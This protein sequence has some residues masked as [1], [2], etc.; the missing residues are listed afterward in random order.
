[1]ILGLTLAAAAL[2][3]L[4]P[5]PMKVL[6]DHVLQPSPAHNELER[7]FAHYGLS[8]SRGLFLGIAAIGTVALFALYS[9]LEAALVSLWTFAGRRMVYDVAQDLFAQLQR[10]SLI[11]HARSSVGNLLATITGDSW[12]V[13]K[14]VDALLYAPFHAALTIVLMVVLMAKLDMKLMLLSVAIAPLMV[15]A[16]LLI[17]KPLHL[18]AKWKRE[19]E[20]RIQAHIQQTLTGIPV[21]QSFAQ[22]ERERERLEQFADAAIRAQQRST[23][24]GSINSL[25]SGLITTLGTSAVLWIGARHVLDGRLTL[26]SLLVF[27]VY[28]T[29][30]QA[31]MKAFTNL[32]TAVRGIH[33]NVDRVLDVLDAPPEVADKPNA[34]ALSKVRGKVRFEDVTFGYEPGVPVLRGV[35]LTAD[36]GDTIALVG[37]TGAGKS[38][39]F[40]LLPR[41]FD[42]WEG[43]VLLDDCDVRTMRLESLR[44]Q[45]GI[46]LQESFLSP[47]SIAENIAFGKPDA[48]RDEI[49]FAAR[50]A[51]AHVFIERLPQGYDTI[52][53]ERGCT[54]SGG[55]RQRLAIARAFLKN[56]P[57]LI[58]DEPTSALDAET[59]SLLLDA[60]KRL[61]SGRTTFIIAHRLSTVRQA[62]CILV[63]ENGIIAERGT[64]NELLMQGGVYARL[65]EM[66]FGRVPPV[67][68]EPVKL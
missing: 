68:N 32:Y 39:L 59:E 45:I 22:E 26:G 20:A 35:S 12:C 13:Y 60:L 3:A 62:D 18:A 28:L 38:T 49:E 24:L 40:N 48:S 1:V 47:L 34:I 58:L 51:S 53:G 36:P 4:Q 27:V 11:F 52:I 29:S 66:Q 67:M 6:V 54:L 5:W 15:A 56:A 16:S 64:H 8:T 50:A 7:R 30:L 25:S 37:A 65:H 21:V 41:F 55:E 46:V 44:R 61:M 57:I 2:S 43:R 31:Q 10:R 23:L 19:I 9:A 63:L 14:L 17:G 33:V 42:P